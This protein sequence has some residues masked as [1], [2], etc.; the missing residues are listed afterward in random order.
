MDLVGDRKA[1]LLQ[2]KG[3]TILL[4]GAVPGEDMGPSSILKARSPPLTSAP[5]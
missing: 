3:R 5:L 4:P 2:E 1:Q